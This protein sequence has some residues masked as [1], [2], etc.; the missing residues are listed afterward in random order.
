[1]RMRAQVR[2]CGYSEPEMGLEVL[3]GRIEFVVDA[4]QPLAQV[5]V[6]V[7]SPQMGPKAIVVI[8]A[9][10]AELA[11]RVALEGSAIAVAFLLVVFEL[12][13]G[14]DFVFLCKNLAIF[15]AQATHLLF[16]LP[17]DVSLQLFQGGANKR[18]FPV[19]WASRTFYSSQLTAEL[20]RLGIFEKSLPF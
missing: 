9:V 1:M 4:T 8:E 15:D 5:T 11:Q 2:V 7:I 3:V 20:M 18:W 16:V 13:P 10:V 17:P 6:E 14:E 19:R 12:I